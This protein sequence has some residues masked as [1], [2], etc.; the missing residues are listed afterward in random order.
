MDEES[1][2][3]VF[4][5]VGL[6]YGDEGKGTTVDFL[7]REYKAELVV[8]YNGGP[9]AAHHVVIENGTWHCFAQFGS[10]LFYLFLFIFALSFV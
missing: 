1:H 6:F 8:R 2:S 7:T 10:S 9:Q 5:I 4:A 3:S